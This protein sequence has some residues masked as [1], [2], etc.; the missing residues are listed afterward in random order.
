[1]LFKNAVRSTAFDINS[2]V[3]F[4]WLVT[5]LQETVTHTVYFYFTCIRCSME[6]IK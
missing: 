2:L 1:M 4:I 5:V 6:M 3:T